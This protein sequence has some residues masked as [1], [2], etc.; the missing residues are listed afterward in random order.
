MNYRKV[1]LGYVVFVA[2]EE[3][4]IL[5]ASEHVVGH[6]SEVRGQRSK[7]KASEQVVLGQF[8]V[9]ERQLRE[10]ASSH[11]QTLKRDATRFMREKTRK[12]S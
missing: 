9:D 4:K 11:L 6:R 10:R 2:V 5:D 8:R 1:L 7:V 3:A 12:P